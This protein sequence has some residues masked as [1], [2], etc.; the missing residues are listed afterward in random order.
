MDPAPSPSPR[1]RPRTRSAFG[2]LLLVFASAA[3]ALRCQA[4]PAAPAA[5]ADAA[6]D[7]AYQ[8]EYAGALGAGGARLGAQIVAR[9]QGRFT[10]V[11]LSGGLPGAGWDQAGRSEIAGSL[12]ADGVHFPAPAAGGYAA[13]LS[14]DGATL[15]GTTPQGE[16][17]ALPKA[18]RESP[19]LGAAPPAGALVLFDGRDLDAFVKGSAVLDSGLLLP[20]GSAS[21]GAVTT[22]AF[23]SFTLHLEFREPF[24]PDYAGQARG[25]S[26]VYLQGRYEL[27]ILD[28]FGLDILRD[29]PGGATQECGAFYQLVAPRLNMSLPPLA[30]QTYDVGFAKAVFDSAGKTLLAPAKVTVRLNG[31]LIHENQELKSSTLLGDPVSAADGPI[32]FQAHGDPVV[33]RNIWIV[34]GDPSPI[35]PA[36]RTGSRAPGAAF[37]AGDQARSDAQGRALP[38]RPASGTYYGAAA[39]GRGA[40]SVMAK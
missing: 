12:Q 16:A 30:W 20:Q 15:A 40:I 8:G 17:F 21:S 33:Y 19:T 39:D 24:M 25:N 26:G 3:L 6:Q 14:A 13:V 36:P 1:R 7:F 35:R 29:G 38:G 28:S 27:Q 22:R 4:S 34:E 10:A 32:R 5:P 23:G 11:F 9:G 18:R 37:P 31:V 2:R